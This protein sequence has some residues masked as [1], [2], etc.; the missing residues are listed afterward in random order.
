[1]GFYS[2]DFANQGGDPKDLDAC[3]GKYKVTY[4][5]FEIGPV[6]GANARPVFQ[7]LQQQSNHAPHNK[8]EPNWNFN[9]YLIS[10]SGELVGHWP[11][12]TYPG[13][14]PD[15]PQDGLIAKAIVAELAK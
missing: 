7:W 4:P 12:G 10:R 1:M 8:S 14:N 2:N 9:K 13:G 5:E 15:D 3:S 6:K 11:S